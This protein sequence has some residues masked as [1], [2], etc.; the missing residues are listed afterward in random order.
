MHL[1]RRRFL[2]LSGGAALAWGATPLWLRPGLAAVEA[3]TGAGGGAGPGR[4]LLVMLWA[5]GND[6]LNTLIP[7]GAPEYYSARPTIAYKPDNVLTL[8]GSRLVGLHPNLVNIHGLYKA[9][10]VA[11][12]QGVGYDRPDLSHTA[13]MDVW[14]TASPTHA[15]ASGWLGRWLDQAPDEGSV[16]RAV[17]VG[18]SLP[19]AL[20]G[21]R[22]SGVAVPSLGGFTF[23]DGADADPKSEA[24]RRHDQF[25]HSMDSHLD[26]EAAAAFMGAARRTVTAVR[27][28]NGLGAGTQAPATLA[29]QV[30]LAMTLLSS[31]LGVRV[32]MVTL[33]GFDDHA[34]EEKNHPGLLKQV[35]DAVGR[36][37]DA[38]AKLPNAGD[39]LMLTF[40]EFGRRVAEDGS[41]GTDHGTAAPL[42][43]IGAGVAGGLH[44]AQPSLSAGRL[45]ENG[46]MVRAVEL[47]EVYAT[48][49]DRWLGGPG[50]RDVLRYS[51]SD[52]L[53]PV[54][55][56]R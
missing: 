54:A 53:H 29:D 42:F 14:H 28:V 24:R 52:A 55:F 12:V 15:V 8:A 10:Q 48:V 27:A 26:G 18:S 46:N 31:N 41:G 40:S 25:L 16:L 4:K 5:G 17:A 50:S 9:G 20:V 37:R 51:S 35:D 49:L 34:G 11:I 36:Y 43:A 22:E 45:D 47:R 7:Y 1:T 30:D 44:G 39:Y 38:L 2:Q 21:E 33:G 32:A 6:G 23:V 13:S 19:P 56:L 3:A